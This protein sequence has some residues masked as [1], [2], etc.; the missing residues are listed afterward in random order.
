MNT[1]EMRHLPPEHREAMRVLLEA[2]TRCEALGFVLVRAARM[3][4]WPGSQATDTFFDTKVS[5]PYEKSDEMY[6][7]VVADAIR[8]IGIQWVNSLDPA[9]QYIWTEAKERSE[10]TND[11]AVRT[12]AFLEGILEDVVEWSNENHAGQLTRVAEKW[13]PAQPAG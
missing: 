11:M 5:V 12:R 13:T 9:V 6:D 8:D 10:D 2:E 4:N 7:H 1:G 3:E